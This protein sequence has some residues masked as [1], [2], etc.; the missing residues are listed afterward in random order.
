MSSKAARA[1]TACSNLR[2]RA[3]PAPALDRIMST[4]R[5]YISALFVDGEQTPWRVHLS[6]QLTSSEIL[7]HVLNGVNRR[8][9]IRI[10]LDEILVHHAMPKKKT[11][12]LVHH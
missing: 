3:A 4:C 2:F 10:H 11:I 1:F 7:L 12:Y 8:S 5:Q 6:L 9:L